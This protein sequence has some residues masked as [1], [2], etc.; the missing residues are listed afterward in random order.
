MRNFIFPELNFT[1]LLQNLG[2][3]GP[4]GFDLIEEFYN[5]DD[6]G[7]L[8]IPL[9]GDARSSLCWLF[10]S[11]FGG[12][13]GLVHPV[14]CRVFQSTACAP[15]GTASSDSARPLGSS[16]SSRR[17]P[18]REPVGQPDQHLVASVHHSFSGAWTLTIRR[19]TPSNFRIILL[20]GCQRVKIRRA[21][22]LKSRS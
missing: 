6:L 22:K 10:V 20:I 14:R 1:K 3:R 13:R 15:L 19:L 9:K 18:P 11:M 4:D 5:Q 8:I 16:S 17:A 2:D 21:R 12:V 7:Q